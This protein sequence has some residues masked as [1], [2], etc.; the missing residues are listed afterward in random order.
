M[1]HTSLFFKPSEL[2]KLFKASDIDIPIDDRIFSILLKYSIF[3]SES[4]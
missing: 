2:K 3:S 1:L 4:K